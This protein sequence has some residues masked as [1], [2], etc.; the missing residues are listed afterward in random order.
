[1]K[2]A[3]VITTFIGTLAINDGNKVVGFRLIGEKEISEKLLRTKE[4]LI[5]E[6]KELMEELKKEGFEV[7]KGNEEK[8]NF[9][10]ENLFEIA[11]ELKVVKDRIEFNS[12]ISR[13][14][15]E[16]ARLNIKK[17][18]RK[19]DL[20]LHANNAIEELDKVINVFIERLR[21]WYS[22]HFPEL[23]KAIKDHEKFVKLVANYGDRK[24][25]ENTEFED[26]AKKSMGADFSLADL[27]IIKLFSQNILNLF[28]LRKKLSS[29]LEKT[30]K[31]IAPNLT[32]IAGPTLAAKLIAKAGSLEKL[33]KLP[34]STIQLIGSEKALFR[35]LR[36]KGKSPKHGIIFV[37]PLIQNAPKKLRGKI[38]RVLASK[39][40]I[41]AKL[42]YF[43]KE[44]RAD[45]LKKELEERIKEIF[46]G[47]K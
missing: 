9:V 23:E 41:A 16:I 36:G 47:K 15:A 38:A 4:E 12:L 32:E 5:E 46:G 1:M 25:F 35:F 8:E 37:H 19:D 34:S 27:K 22:L 42:D 45:K 11:K 44:Y 14:G 20:I 7:I 3:F 30:L 17:A 26:L 33:A 40:S 10:K 24:S 28:S 2:K 18:I 31:E 29:Y 21:D 6:E 13:I 43:S 39:L